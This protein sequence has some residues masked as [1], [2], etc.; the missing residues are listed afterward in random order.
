MLKLLVLGKGA[1]HRRIK[2]KN[3]DIRIV[4]N[5]DISSSKNSDTPTKSV[6]FKNNNNID[7]RTIT[8]RHKTEIFRGEGVL[9]EAGA[10]DT[11]GFATY[12]AQS[13]KER[14]SNSR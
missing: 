10:D 5:G 13:A 8:R 6:G 1:R 12:R 14:D 2:D 9:N 7:D 3:S 11:S 4:K